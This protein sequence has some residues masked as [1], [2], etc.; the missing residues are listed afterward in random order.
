[1]NDDLISR[2]H[3]IEVVR[4]MVHDPD[5]GDDAATF[6]CMVWSALDRMP[7][8]NAAPQWISAQDRLPDMYGM[9]CLLYGINQY[10][11]GRV[12]EGFT[13]YM[14]TGQLIW[15]A[16]SAEIDIAALNVSHWMPLPEPPEDEN[17]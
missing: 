10:G 9:P 3:A 4:E 11:Q 2:A 8:V 17:S 7:T 12:F 1:M 16:T 5:I 13:G 6:G 15:H 14:R